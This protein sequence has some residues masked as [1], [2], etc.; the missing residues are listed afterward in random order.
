MIESRRHSQP[1]GKLDS[2]EATGRV[3]RETPRT[4]KI[5]VGWETMRGEARRPR[6]CGCMLCRFHV[7]SAFPRS[8][9]VVL[10]RG[11]MDGKSQGPKPTLAS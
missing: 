9:R 7:A 10:Q 1:T 11:S 6:A 5:G 2:P 4:R 3:G 8:S